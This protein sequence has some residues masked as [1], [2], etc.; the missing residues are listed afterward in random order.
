[1]TQ[2]KAGDKAPNF[3]GLDEQGNLITKHQPQFYELG[4]STP[5]LIMQRILQDNKFS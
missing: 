1:M 3:S 2:L 4:K 5:E